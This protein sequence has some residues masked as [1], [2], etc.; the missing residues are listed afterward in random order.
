MT[1]VVE[2][3][4]K[5]ITTFNTAGDSSAMCRG[6]DGRIYIVYVDN[7]TGD[8]MMS[9]SRD[10]GSS[11][12]G[13]ELVL[14]DT[15]TPIYNRPSIVCDKNGY[16]HVFIYDSAAA[17]RSIIEVYRHTSSRNWSSPVVVDSLASATNFY[18]VAVGNNKLWCITG[19]SSNTINV[20]SSTVL[21]SWGTETTMSTTYNRIDVAVDA[22]DEVHIVWT[23]G[24]ADAPG[25]KY[26][27]SFDGPWEQKTLFFGN[28]L[29]ISNN[30]DPKMVITTDNNIHCVFP[31]GSSSASA[32]YFKFNPDDY[33]GDPFPSDIIPQVIY[34]GVGTD[35]T[36]NVLNI[37]TDQMS[38]IFIYEAKDTGLTFAYWQAPSGSSIFTRN[39][40]AL[41][42]R[43]QNQRGAVSSLWPVVTIDSTDRYLNLPQ[44]GFI[45][46]N[47]SATN[48]SLSALYTDGLVFDELYDNDSSIIYGFTYGVPV[49]TDTIKGILYSQVENS[50][51][52]G[53]QQGV[54]FDYVEAPIHINDVIYSTSSVTTP[55]SNNIARRFDGK[56]FATYVSRSTVPTTSGNVY[57]VQSDDNG[58]TWH[59][60]QI[61][62][63]DT[64][65]DYFYPNIAITSDGTIHI[66]A[67]EGTTED[68]ISHVYK[69][70]N[71]TSWSSKNTV[72]NVSASFTVE[73]VYSVVGSGND[74]WTL[75]QYSSTTQGLK[76]HRWNGST[77]DGGTLVSGSV[78]SDA[79][80]LIID[81]IG[82]P[83]LI[84]QNGSTPSIMYA[85][86]YD[87]PYT[88]RTLLAG[89]SGLT[90]TS[91]RPR[92]TITP[93]DVGHIIYPSGGSTG[94]I[95]YFNFQL[96]ASGSGPVATQLQNIV[97]PSSGATEDLML[98]S[99][100]AQNRVYIEYFD[101]AS[102]G[103][104]NVYE[105]SMG[106][107]TSWSN[108]SHSTVR[109][110]PER[111]ITSISS[112]FPKIDDQHIN[113]PKFGL[114]STVLETTQ[115]PDELT[116]IFDNLTEWEY[117]YSLYQVIKGYLSSVGYTNE[118]ILGF[119]YGISGFDESTVLGYTDG[120]GY[121]SSNILGR[122]TGGELGDESTIIGYLNATILANPSTILGYLSGSPPL[123]SS[124][125]IGFIWGDRL[126][127]TTI[128][129]ITTGVE[130]QTD[131]ILGF[132]IGNLYYAEDIN[133]YL[134]G[135]LGDSTS[136]IGGY[137]YSA[138]ISDINGHLNG[139]IDVS[140]SSV[141]GVLQ[142]D[143]LVNSTVRGLIVA[144]NC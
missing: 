90:T 58:L 43:Y 47:Y 71:D 32:F 69:G 50:N 114:Y 91:T 134:Y 3:L 132:I 124:D 84:W 100:D 80:E 121:L 10:G 99:G 136:S 74:I 35:T 11:W 61:V 92:A 116:L 23:K 18:N 52:L 96:P 51:I 125:I 49:E 98:I 42:I 143:E 94:P 45:L 108:T 104:I 79:C 13:A 56:L 102:G 34:T 19:D 110:D 95:Y 81:S 144:D 119:T 15:G 87:G 65:E 53:Y 21:G 26:A 109:S 4:I 101:A 9:W 31:S 135:I 36:N 86:S 141:N 63:Q 130:L 30:T 113:M 126:L 1:D 97:D 25:L 82:R 24:S 93:N 75:V 78:N 38:N 111:V 72:E 28:G 57:V 2:S 22:N 133:G 77:W 17:S 27:N 107:Y 103:T 59:S 12:G 6:T 128:I 16:I 48:T 7:S 131:D 64:V 55:R 139:I 137:I 62:M 5:N 140:D 129:G 41:S 85:N 122:L 117:P 20:F 39:T 73:E 68:K 115:S 88:Q 54:G 66:I 123:E 112:L 44:S 37:S 127:Q 89:A 83:H 142:G 40:K 46:Q 60:N 76:I 14:L 105:S 106:E 8:V 138:E 118:D 33:I 29:T 67:Y 70:I 120:M